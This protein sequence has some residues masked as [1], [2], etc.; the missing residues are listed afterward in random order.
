[1]SRLWIE[2]LLC[3]ECAL[4]ADEPQCIVRCPSGAIFEAADNPRIKAIH[5]RLPEARNGKERR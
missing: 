3:T 1:M 4:Y 2:P 5:P